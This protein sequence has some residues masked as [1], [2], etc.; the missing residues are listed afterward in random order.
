[1]LA[2]NEIYDTRNHRFWNPDDQY[3]FEE[4]IA[5]MCEDGNQAHFNARQEAI[6]QVYSKYRKP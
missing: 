5:I 2:S 3:D 6:K 1:M 4:R